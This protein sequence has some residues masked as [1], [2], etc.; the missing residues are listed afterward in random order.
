MAKD[1]VYKK[2]VDEKA[3]LGG[4]ARFLGKV[5][6]FC[7]KTCRAAFQ[8]EPRKY[9]PEKTGEKRNRMTMEARLRSCLDFFDVEVYVHRRYVALP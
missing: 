8:R 9:L 7:S 5:F 6:Y 3:A 2:E 4:K 1:P